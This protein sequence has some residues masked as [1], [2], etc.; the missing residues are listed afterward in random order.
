M[1]P[2]QL[3]SLPLLPEEFGW[4]EVEGG[5]GAEAERG[6]PKCELLAKP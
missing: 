6:E 2:L 1:Q 5:G 3:S 4:S